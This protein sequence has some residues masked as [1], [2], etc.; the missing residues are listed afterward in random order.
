M[1]GESISKYQVY[2]ISWLIKNIEIILA[3]ISLRYIVTFE[4]F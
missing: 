4:T 2:F 1:L 3:M